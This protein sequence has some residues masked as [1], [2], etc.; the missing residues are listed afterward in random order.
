[1]A[2]FSFTEIGASTSMTVSIPV[3]PSTAK[4]DVSITLRADRL[5]VSIAGHARQP[6]VLDGIL[7]YDVDASTFSWELTGSGDARQLL[8]ELDKAEPIEWEGL[9]R[10]HSVDM[11][12]PPDV[13]RNLL[14]PQA[15]MA[16]QPAAAAQPALSKSTTPPPGTA[17]VN[18][19]T[20]VAA[21]PLRA[22]KPLSYKKWD[23]LVVSDDEEEDVKPSPGALGDGEIWN[24]LMS[25][26]K[27]LLTKDGIA[28]QGWTASGKDGTGT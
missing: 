20:V 17:S 16:A 21:E 4:Q 19:R 5:R 11:A 27:R 6:N 3:P 9:F 22:T 18:T 25:G 14:A 13:P 23:S 26:K 12:P 15:T 7:T 8:I 28:H 10:D 2:I 1:M 24:D